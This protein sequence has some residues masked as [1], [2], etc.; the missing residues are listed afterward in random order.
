M[1][2]TQATA[3]T[4]RNDPFLSWLPNQFIPEGK[5][6]LPFVGVGSLYRPTIIGGKWPFLIYLIKT[7][8]QA[9]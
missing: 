5:F 9:F 6:I 2:A 8:K 4:I 3:M 7:K 1:V